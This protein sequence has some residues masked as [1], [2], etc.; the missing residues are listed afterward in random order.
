MNKDREE[1][2]SA[3]LIELNK[4]N[5]SAQ[6]NLMDK[7]FEKVNDVA[8]DTKDIKD[9]V[10]PGKALRGRRPPAYDLSNVYDDN[11]SISPIGNIQAHMG[12]EDYGNVETVTSS[13][14]DGDE[15][16]ENGSEVQKKPA[17][18]A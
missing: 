4:E 8:N 7:I 9:A 2:N 10:T 18:K 14:S 15:G 5:H 6:Q 1:A 17:Y 13:S 16:M 12:F 11:L 3:T